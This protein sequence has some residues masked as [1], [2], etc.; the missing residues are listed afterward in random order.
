MGRTGHCEKKDLRKDI[1]LTLTVHR[2]T[3]QYEER[4]PPKPGQELPSTAWAARH[5]GSHAASRIP[6]P[7]EGDVW[8]RTSTQGTTW[9][10]ATAR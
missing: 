8:A 1:D 5:K 3:K 10:G 6:E 7:C 9:P 4:V 2:Q